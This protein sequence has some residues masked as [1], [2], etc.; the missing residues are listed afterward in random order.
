MP[1]RS[2]NIFTR[3]MERLYLWPESPAL[4]L[5]VLWVVTQALFWAARVPMHRGLRALGSALG[6]SLRLASRWLRSTSEE[7]RRRNREVLLEAGRAEAAAKVEHEFQRLATIYT[8]DL[9][10][11]PA[12]HRQLDET[13]KKAE[14][15]FKASTLAPPDA[16]GWPEAVQAV[17]NMPKAGDRT[18]Q[19]VLE[20]IHKAAVVQ[21]KKSLQA[22]REATAKRHEILAK[23][24]VHWKAIRGLL[25][26]VGKAVAGTLEASARVDAFMARYEK[27]SRGEDGAERVL[28]GSAL[29]LF[30]ISAFVVLVAGFGALVNFQLVARPMSELV[31]GGGWVL[32]MPVSMI[33]ALVI[34]LMEVAAG[35]FVMETLGIT[36]LF[37]RIGALPPSRK[38]IIFGVALAG[39]FLLAAIE[40]SLAILREQLLE[41]DK[42]LAL[43]LAGEV[44]RGK[45][46]IAAPLLSR[47]PVIGQAVL[48]FV[49]P[50]ILAMIAVPLEMLVESGRHVIGRALALLVRGLGA[51]LRVLGH[52]VRHLVTALEHVYDVTII[53]P[54]QLE[55][56][57]RGG[58]AGRLVS[59]GS[60]LRNPAEPT[61]PLKAPR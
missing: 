59:G 55:R 30:V 1:T 26:Q 7:L 25:E 48:G 27:I 3:D 43:A 32:G 17:A 47:I 56:L 40:A 2:A 9:K 15:E 22:Y 53:V 11:Y 20:E 34:I 28:A 35:I 8:S 29:N 38:R 6:G 4:S 58:A 51:L 16:P 37:P 39:L 52:L 14:E 5:L 18:V 54:L 13:V 46:A 45:E 50:W 44:V 49:L 41:A 42:A 23:S 61:A 21:E 33:A 57:A 24:A 36:Q 19:K 10:Q 12:L 60:S 31:A